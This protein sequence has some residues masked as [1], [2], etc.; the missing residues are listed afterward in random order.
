MSD[1]NNLRELCVKM[2]QLQLDKDVHD[3]AG[4]VLA[5][6]LDELR[7][8]QIPAL[9]DALEVKTATFEGIGRVQLAGD[10]YCSTAAGRKD[11]AMQW[12]KDCGYEEM[13]SESYNATSMKALVRRLITDGTEIPDFMNVTPFIRASIVKG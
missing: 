3:E 7:L 9:M 2:R 10:L 5:A 11:E 8:R 13:I 1:M 6:E 12:L 4:K